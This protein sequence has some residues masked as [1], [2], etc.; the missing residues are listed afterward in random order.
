MDHGVHVE[1]RDTGTNFS[2]HFTRRH[3]IKQLQYTMYVSNIYK[4]KQFA[5]KRTMPNEK[6]TH[7]Y[8]STCSYKLCISVFTNTILCTKTSHTI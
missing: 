6:M 3:N 4:R 1:F 2:D 5:I 7:H 8:D